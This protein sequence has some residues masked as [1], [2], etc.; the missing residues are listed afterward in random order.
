MRGLLGTGKGTKGILLTSAAAAAITA[1]TASPSLVLAQDLA[2]EEIVVTARKREESILDAPL[3]VTA[4]SQAELQNAG[5]TNIIDVSKATPGLFIEKFNQT[6]AR[7]NLTPRFRGVYLSTGDRLQQT[8]TVF[9]DGVAISGGIETIGINEL[10]RIEISKGPQSALYG[11]NTFAGAINYITKD[12]GDEFRSDASVTIATRDEY[13]LAAGV[14]GPISDALAFRIGASWDSSEG[15][16][17]NIAV[18]GDTL[19]DESQWNVNGSLVFEPNDSLRMKFRASYREVH[20][21]PAAIIGGAFGPATHNFGGFLL[22]ANCDAV[23]SDVVIPSS[24]SQC[25]VG[26]GGRSNSIFQGVINGSQIPASEIGI[27]SDFASIEAFRSAFTSDSRFTA[28]NALF[29][30]VFGYNP[31]EKD[32]FGLDLDEVRLSFDARYDINDHIRFSLL[33][34]YSEESYG[35]FTELDLSPDSSFTSFIANDIKDFSV[36][37]RFEGDLFEE[38]LNW[39]VGFSYVDVEILA[40]DGTINTFLFPIVFSNGLQTDEFIR[41]AK[42]LGVFGSLDY[43]LTD[44]ISVIFEGRYQEDEIIDEAVNV[45]VPGLSPA[46][47]TNFV[48]RATIQ[49]EPSETTTLYATYSQGNLPGGFNPQVAELDD[50]AL[51]DVL[52]RVPEADITF[53]EETLTNYELGWK[54]SLLGG[55]AAFNLAAFYMRRS[56]EIARVLETAPDNR[57]GAPNPRRTVAFNVNGAT[58]DIYGF[59]LDGSWRVTTEWSLSGSVAYIDAKIASFP[60]DAGT[61]RFGF[62]FGPN[63]DVSGQRAPRFPPLAFSLSSTYESEFNLTDA[64]DSW[65]VRGDMFYSGQFYTSNANQT[66]VESAVDMNLRLGLRSDR[67]SIEFFV[68][69]LLDEDAPAAAQTFADTSLDVRTAPGG[70]FNFNAIGNRLALRDK[71]QFGVRARVNF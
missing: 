36:E 50:A 29:S 65:F 5:F 12:P 9:L 4:F 61:D 25:V 38:Q 32:D 19:G 10:Q 63:A 59:E 68:T 18:P 54:Q 22:D 52:T 37:T 55:S 21:G 6:Q 17:D 30:G 42:T 66:E 1:T 14:E 15:H 39:A 71:R 64:F 67:S 31:A 49:Y 45:D 28:D 62:V 20:D 53:D 35:I 48:P 70:F 43:Q 27:N 11:R 24:N 34:G 56:D 23:T 7:V 8:A 16:Y 41:G 13:S 44:E 46:T 26:V 69:N 33:A 57:P 60:E 58:T 47:L 3:A 40:G 2:L 51:A